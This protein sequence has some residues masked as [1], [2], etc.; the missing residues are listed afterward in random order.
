MLHVEPLT[1][2]FPVTAHP[3]AKR[4]LWRNKVVGKGLG[5][6]LSTYFWEEKKT[7]RWT[8]DP[9]SV[10]SSGFYCHVTTKH[11]RFS[12]I[13]QLPH[14]QSVCM[15]AVNAWKGQFGQIRGV[16]RSTTGL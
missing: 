15:Y 14:F 7:K 4:I 10:M 11:K 16:F 8:E 6:F 2:Y 5:E 9:C 12:D 3:Q 13:V 1:D